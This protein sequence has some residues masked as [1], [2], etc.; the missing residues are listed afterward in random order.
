LLKIIHGTP[1]PL[2]QALPNCPPELESILQRALAKNPEERYQTATELALD[3]SHVQDELK[4]ERVSEYLQTAEAYIAE[5]HWAKAQEQLL[6][7][8]KLDRQNARSSTLLRQVQQEI[9]KQQRSERAKDLRCQADQALTKGQFDEALRY[10]GMAVDLVPTDT[11]LS[12]LRDSVKEMKATLDRLSE[13][14]RRA[15]SAHDAG[16]LEDALA[17]SEEALD[18]DQENTEARALQ[19]VIKREIAER[20]KLKQVQSFIDEARK[21]IS[22]RRFTAALEVLEKAEKLDPGAAGINDLI[23]LASTG[24]QQE[25]RRKELDQ[26][27]ADV[28]EALNRNEYVGACE[29]AEAGLR[30]FPDD[31]GLLKLK[32][33][34]D[35]ER[36]AYEKRTYIENVVSAARRLLED[37]RG[38]DALRA[39]EE[40]LAQYPEEFVLLSM[41]A[42]VTES[43]ERELA[44]HV[45]IQTIQHAK[46]AIRR[47]AYNEAIAVLQA[48]QQKTPCSE[49]EDLLLFAADEA[50]AHEKRVLIDS[51]VDEAHRL[52][53]ADDFASAMSLLEETLK[54]ADDQELRIILADARRQLEQFASGVTET[55]SAA[56]RLLQ[57]QRFFEAVKFMEGQLET[58]RKSPEFC[59]ALERMRWEERRVHAFSTVKE[60]VRELLAK[61]DYESA[62]SLIEEFQQDFGGNADTQ[63]LRNEIES[64]R[65]KGATLAV[66]QALND[67]RIL[68]LVNSYSTALGILDRVANDATRVGS[69]LRDKYE[70]VRS[71][72]ET[73]LKQQRQRREQDRLRQK[74]LADRLSDQPTLEQAHSRTADNKDEHTQ[75]A[76]PAELEKLLGEVTLLG[77]HYEEDSEL[78]DEISDLRHQLTAQIAELR[79]TDIQQGS[80]FPSPQLSEGHAGLS[81]PEPEMVPTY[82][83]EQETSSDR[84]AEDQPHKPEVPGAEGDPHRDS[85]VS[86]AS[87]DESA[88][89]HATMSLHPQL[90][91]EDLQGTLISPAEPEPETS[92]EPVETILAQDIQSAQG[93]TSVAPSDDQDRTLLPPLSQDSP[94]RVGEISDV[95]PAF[96]DLTIR[97]EF[98]QAAAGF[99]AEAP[100]EAEEAESGEDEQEEG[101]PAERESAIHLVD[102]QE[103]SSPAQPTVLWPSSAPEP[104]YVAV[105]ETQVIPI[106]DPDE[107]PVRIHTSPVPAELPNLRVANPIEAPP[108]KPSRM[109]EEGARPRLEPTPVS[110]RRAARPVP[111]LAPKQALTAAIALIGVVAISIGL[112]FLISQPKKKSS[113]PPSSKIAMN[114]PDP[115]TLQQ[116]QALTDSD[117]RVA[118][119]DLEGAHQI[120]Q[121]AASVKGA[122]TAEINKRLEGIDAAMND[123]DLR[124][125][126][127]R[128]EQL[129]QA[130]QADV[131]GGHFVAGQKELRQILALP[132]GATRKEAAQRYLDETVP[133]RKKEESLFAEAQRASKSSDPGELQRARDLFGEVIAQDGP[134]KNQA[135][136]LRSSI[137]GHLTVLKQ[138]HEQSMATLI[139]QARQALNQ[140]NI[141]DARQKTE[142]ARQLGADTSE[143]SGDIDQADKA[144]QSKAAADATFQRTV[145]RYRAAA[146]A[147]DKAGLES[148]RGDLL[149]VAQAGGAHVAEAQ[150]YV[151]ELD[152]KVAALNQPVVRPSPPTKPAASLPNEEEAIRTVVQRYAQAFE[153]RDA[154]ALREIWPSLSSS[155]YSSYQTNFANASAIRMHVEIT[156]INLAADLGSATVSAL[157]TQKYTPNGFAARVSKDTALFQMVKQGA[158]LYITEVR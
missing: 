149:A 128:E 101:V 42:L 138:Q 52:I 61:S 12:K 121:N 81:V 147:N 32:A 79:E 19:G 74:V 85:T 146:S 31:R 90:P 30:K 122:L 83:L 77:Q 72:T 5:R 103:P 6:Q 112:H 15:E 69:E 145:Q 63:L 123:A 82:K 102:E 88:A 25:R 37:R 14:L 45:K 134:R 91:V 66:E 131:T 23:S 27:A 68:L 76:S 28:Q 94:A 55:I 127:Q 143:L 39:L 105:A 126:R 118:A 153:K 34:A 13:L 47:K 3:L 89:A 50:L 26:I 96:A 109:R 58:Y 125:L 155:M 38:E 133:R 75:R 70:N 141:R 157:V 21:Q 136:E 93:E 62:L 41:H 11:D 110:G 35:K 87:W 29:R 137:A 114:R 111:I 148:V 120:L 98:D 151:A 64:K 115:A 73:S 97:T 22:S 156:T 150:S 116:K 144:L 16:D 40:A 129:W 4:H 119:G 100:H 59:A 108:P 51:T 154:D 80:E 99:G 95:P 36:E 2:S 43:V 132:E 104:P 130:A 17:A 24:Q 78:K 8:L 57:A 106:S 18:L 33:L 56:N 84:L 44:E 9:Q 53:S 48:A 54:K 86:S 139:A 65:E 49:F 152:R 140:G 20:A 7:V 107:K 124:K 135:A 10:L 46:D 71:K 60:K 92:H 1:P 113:A 158:A 67:V 117:N 142:A